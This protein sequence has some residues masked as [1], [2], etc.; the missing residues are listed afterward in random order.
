MFQLRLYVLEPFF[1]FLWAAR[2]AKFTLMVAESSGTKSGK[3]SKKD[4]KEMEVVDFEFLIMVAE[5][6]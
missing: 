1:H 5:K 6:C 4:L 2:E 3:Y